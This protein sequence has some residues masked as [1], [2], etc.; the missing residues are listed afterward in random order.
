MTTI[1]EVKALPEVNVQKLAVGNK[2]VFRG[3]SNVLLQIIEG[4]KSFAIGQVY[5]IEAFH[6][7]LGLGHIIKVEGVS[8]F[9]FANLFADVPAD[10]VAPTPE[11]TADVVVDAVKTV[12]SD[13]A[14]APV[15]QDATKAV[16]DTVTAATTVAP[17]VVEAVTAVADAAPAVEAATTNPV[18][19][20]E[21][22]ATATTEVA[23]A[24]TAVEQAAPAVEADVQAAVADATK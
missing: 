11:E 4:Q 22:V 8:G 16:E 9:H 13:V 1:A 10:F 5:T 3:V 12:E 2:V 15:V 19:A 20:V 14:N 24:V 7:L 23:A 18:A 6:N 17:A 21:A